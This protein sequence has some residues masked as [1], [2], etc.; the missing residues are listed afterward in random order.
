MQ[1]EISQGAETDNRRCYV[2]CPTQDIKT[3]KTQQK[4]TRVAGDRGDP[5][6]GEQGACRGPMGRRPAEAGRLL[7]SALSVPVWTYEVIHVEV[8]LSTKITPIL[9]K[10]KKSYLLNAFST[11]SR[12]WTKAASTRKDTSRCV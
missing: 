8:M 5:S 3:S 7:V 11:V 6:D 4:H 12:Q 10:K 2:L 9:P 1:S